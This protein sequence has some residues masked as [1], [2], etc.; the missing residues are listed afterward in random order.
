MGMNR[1][2]GEWAVLFPWFVAAGHFSGLL[3]LRGRQWVVV[4][5][6]ALLN[7][8]LF[9]VFFGATM[10]AREGSY[11][12]SG[13]MQS[14]QATSRLIA[15]GSEAPE[16]ASPSPIL[17]A[18]NGFSSYLTQGYYAVALALEEPFLPM[19]GVGHSAF[20]TRQAVRLTG[21]K[22]LLERSY[23][24]RIEQRGWMATVYWATIY[25]WLASDV[26]FLGVIVVVFLIG[27]LFA[28]V[29]VDLLGGRNPLAVALV[30][31]LVL[32][33]YYFPAHNRVLQIGEGVSAFWGLLLLWWLGSSGLLERL[34]GWARR[35]R[36]PREES[37]EVA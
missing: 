20:L 23:P 16:T 19:W 3:R 24:V 27:Y 30:G 7:S 22:S 26:G 11:A 29:W 15:P 37:G 18:I 4:V 25:T 33:L 35:Q 8:A 12:K 1:A 31:Q 14:I 28:R 13:S 9:F 17:V 32:M 36:R 34:S 5:G 2:V 10:N 6:I 21:D